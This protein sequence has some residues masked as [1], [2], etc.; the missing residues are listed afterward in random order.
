M[1][2]VL[3]DVRRELVEAR[4]QNKR[5]QEENNRHAAAAVAVQQEGFGSK[6]VSRKKATRRWAPWLAKHGWRVCDD[7]LLGIEALDA[8]G[9]AITLRFASG[10]YRDPQGYGWQTGIQQAGLYRAGLFAGDLIRNASRSG[11]GETTLINADGRYNYLA[12]VAMDGRLAV[13]SLAS[14]NGVEE[15]LRGTVARVGFERRIVS[16]T[17]RDPAEVLQQPHTVPATQ[18]PMSRRMG[19]RVLTTARRHSKTQVIRRSAGGRAGAGQRAK[20]DLPD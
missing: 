13:L 18:A 10:A 6:S 16:I 7:W 15:V 1:L 2:Q 20:A 17:L 4:K 19:W 12:D 3:Q 11:Y 5:L 8:N 9:D 14:E